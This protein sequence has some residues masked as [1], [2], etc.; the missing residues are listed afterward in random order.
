MCLS[1]LIYLNQR[2][3]PGL[4]VGHADLP[5][6]ISYLSYCR[7]S[8]GLVSKQKQGI[9]KAQSHPWVA[10]HWLRS[11]SGKDQS[12]RQMG[13]MYFNTLCD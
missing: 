1:H 5:K 13:L 8:A 9:K 11:T 12:M 7:P 2:A 3:Q 10:F 6:P 4:V